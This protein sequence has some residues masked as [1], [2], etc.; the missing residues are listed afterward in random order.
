M[1]IL[2]SADWTMAGM[3]TLIIIF[4]IMF[5][6][7]MITQ[8]DVDHGGKANNYDITKQKVNGAPAVC[9]HYIS[10]SCLCFMYREP[11][12]ILIFTFP[13]KFSLRSMAVLSS[14]GH[15]RRSREKNKNRLPGFVAFST[16]T[17]STH[18]DIL[19]TTC[20]VSVFPAN[21]K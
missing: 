6:V 20:L 9:R 2:F 8:E 4:V 5:P 7:A 3:K 17:P 11:L 13:K 16:A 19:L 12:K 21:Q 15:E 14:R 1:I 18:F 10:G